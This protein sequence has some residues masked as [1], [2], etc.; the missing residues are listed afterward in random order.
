MEKVGNW[1]FPKLQ[2]MDP[3]AMDKTDEANIGENTT[4]VGKSILAECQSEHEIKEANRGEMD[5]TD[6]QEKEVNKSYKDEGLCK[7][8]KLSGEETVG[9]TFGEDE[10]EKD[11]SDLETNPFI[12]P[13]LCEEPPKVEYTVS[14]ETTNN[15]NDDCLDLIAKDMLSFAWQISRGMVS[16]DQSL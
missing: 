1:E 11:N 14:Q 4:A 7:A 16:N 10:E 9:K 3:L 6:F 15:A 8:E 12:K 2:N 13:E 5:V